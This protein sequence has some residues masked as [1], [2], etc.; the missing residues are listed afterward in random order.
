VVFLQ[1]P[2]ERRVAIGTARM[3]HR[4]LPNSEL[5]VGVT[6]DDHPRLRALVG[7]RD[8]ALLFP[9][10]AA[11]EADTLTHEPPRTLVVIDGTWRQARKLL[12]VN[13]RLA[14]LP[15]VRVTPVR[16]GRYRVRRE[17]APECASTIEAVVEALGAIEGGR[18][19]FLPLLRAFD[20]MVATQDR[21][22]RRDAPLPTTDA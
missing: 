16:P 1:H 20:H 18:V 9:G 3:A 4:A 5:H 22:R 11:I 8:T 6:F 17:P 14:A 12:H 19:R 13:P 15:R 2:R 7:C 10:P 21:F